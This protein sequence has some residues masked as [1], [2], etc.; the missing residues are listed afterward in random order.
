ML[1]V[2]EGNIGGIAES[3]LMTDPYQTPNAFPPLLRGDA[4]VWRIRIWPAPEELR[5]RA[6]CLSEKEQNHAAKFHFD[7]DRQKYL[8]AHSALRELLSRH[9]QVTPGELSF[10][11]G[12]QQKPSLP[13]RNSVGLSFNL[14][15]SGDF[16]LLA[17]TLEAQIGV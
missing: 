6:T 13:T 12:P 11:Y 2:C 14:A 15:H 17:V 10:E 8:S 4:H 16:A 7:I 3:R 9:L 1:V 5:S